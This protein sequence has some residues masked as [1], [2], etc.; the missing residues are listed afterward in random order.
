MGSFEARGRVRGAAVYAGPAVRSSTNVAS[1][2]SQAA[3][4]SLGG[5]VARHSSGQFAA[6]GAVQTHSCL[7]DQK[8]GGCTGGG[9]SVL[10]AE[11]W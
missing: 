7:E 1:A 11:K 4:A 2:C 3:P 8:R 6:A 10:T 5:K 9:Q